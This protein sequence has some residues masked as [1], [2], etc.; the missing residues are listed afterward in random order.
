MLRVESDGYWGQGYLELFIIHNGKEIHR[1]DN[2]D[3]K[4][5]KRMIEQAYKLGFKDGLEYKGDY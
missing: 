5:V 4:W 1:G 2:K 3:P